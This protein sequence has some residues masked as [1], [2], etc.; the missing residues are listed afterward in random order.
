MSA[1]R[2][3]PTIFRMSGDR[4]HVPKGV[5]TRKKKLIMADLRNALTIGDE[6]F[7]ECANLEEVK[8]PQTLKRIKRRTFYKCK[9]LAAVTLPKD[10]KEI[11]IQAFYFCGLERVIIPD[12]VETIGE[13]AFLNCKKLKEIKIPASVKKIGDRAFAGSNNLERLIFAGEPESIG[14]HIANRQCVFESCPGGLVERY[15]VDNGY[16]IE[17]R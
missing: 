12:G 8:L 1:M 15:A 3:D 2:I 10:L 11:G 9:K 5:A 7:A 17:L 14:E 4:V 13:G 16:R 6:A